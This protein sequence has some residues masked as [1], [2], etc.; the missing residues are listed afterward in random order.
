MFDKI[1]MITRKVFGKYIFERAL[2]IDKY[3]VGT[4]SISDET[5]LKSKKLL[6]KHFQATLRKVRAIN[7]IAHTYYGVIHSL[8]EEWVTPAESQP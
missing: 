7:L 5:R 4:A 1:F 3:I 6:S 2:P 8:S